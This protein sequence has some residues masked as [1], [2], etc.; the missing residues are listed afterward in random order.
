MLRNYISAAFGNIGRN[1]F[2]AGITILGLAVS[3]AAAILIG[4]FLRDEYSFDRFVADHQRVYL[5]SS[6]ITF[7]GAKPAQFD[8]T[9]PMVGSLMK[10]DIPEIQHAA[11]LE[12]SHAVIRRGDVT[13][14]QDLGWADPDF[15]RVMTMPVLAGDPDAA[16]AAPDGLVLTREAARKFFGQ[17]APIGQVLQ[18]NAA[19][20]IPGIPAE[21][22]QLLTSFRPMRVMAILKDIPSSS[23]L[24]V[25]VFASGRSSA[26]LLAL[27]DRHASPFNLDVATYVK[28]KPG[29]AIGAVIKVT[30]LI[31]AIS[32]ISKPSPATPASTR[33]SPGGRIA[34]SPSPCPLA[35]LKCSPGRALSVNCVA[36]RP[37]S[38]PWKR[39]SAKPGSRAS[40]APISAPGFSFT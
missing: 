36:D 10:L 21:E 23:H 12:G 14:Q 17:D 15:F 26:S 7:P 1:G 20:E 22:T 37:W 4:L 24:R 25:Q 28:L 19:L 29:A 8:S 35:A 38:G 39:R 40:T 16:M 2:Y 33:A 5:V 27:E 18:V 9:A 30:K 11:R 32:T 34:G 31:A 13:I 6:T 3:F